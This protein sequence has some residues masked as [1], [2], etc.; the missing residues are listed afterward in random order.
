MV[1]GPPHTLLPGA[2]SAYSLHEGI[3]SSLFEPDSTNMANVAHFM[4]ELATDSTAWAEWKS[5]LP[6]IVNA[7]EAPTATAG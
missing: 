4:C 6:V 1:R 5:R 3:V 7:A 2:V